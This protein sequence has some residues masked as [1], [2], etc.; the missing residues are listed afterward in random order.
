MLPEPSPRSRPDTASSLP[1]PDT[2]RIA[3]LLYFNDLLNKQG[4][5]TWNGTLSGAA[6]ANQVNPQCPFTLDN[7]CCP[8]L[9]GT[10]TG[11]I[12]IGEP[13]M[14]TFHSASPAKAPFTLVYSFA[15]KSYTVSNVQDGIAFPVEGLTVKRKSWTTVWLVFRM[16][17]DV[18]LPSITGIK[19][20]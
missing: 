12:C 15:G 8:V 18:C 4:N 17:P 1:S 11:Y 16:L 5:A 9:S 3:C 13:A 2:N 20:P 10:I 14:L 19:P 7:D 6:S